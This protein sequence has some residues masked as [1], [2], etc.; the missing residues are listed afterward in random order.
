GALHTARSIE[1]LPLYPEERDSKKPT[2]ATILGLFEHQR[3][4]RLFQS[5]RLVETFWDSLSPI[6][7]QV[8][9]L[10]VVNKK[11]YGSP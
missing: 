1:A 7:S 11:G 10:L 5:G 8:L 3:R 4:N 9:D 6:Q 2:A